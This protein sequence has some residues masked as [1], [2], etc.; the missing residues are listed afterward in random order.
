MSASSNKGYLGFEKQTAMGT[1][2]TAGFKFIGCTMVDAQPENIAATAAPV[3]GG[4]AFPEDGYKAAHRAG[5]TFAFEA[6][7]DD[8]GWL[9]YYMG[10][11]CGYS[12]D[13]PVAD[14]STHTFYMA[15]GDDFTIPWVTFVRSAGDLI[16][17]QLID[18]KIATL[19]LAFAAG[20]PVVAT[21]GVIAREAA[22]FSLS[23]TVTLDN[24]PLLVTPDSNALAQI[25]YDEDD[26]L[27][28]VVTTGVIVDFANVLTN[29]E[30]VIGSYRLNDVTLL[31]RAIG[32]TWTGII[33]DDYMWRA[34]YYGAVDGTTWSTDP[35][36]AKCLVKAVSGQFITGT[37]QY[38]LQFE[39]GEA[40]WT[41][42]R[43]PLASQSLIGFTATAAVTVPASGEEFTFTLVNDTDAAYSS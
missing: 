4:K 40:M 5:G 25:D 30:F 26:T 13:T 35:V 43:C 33:E 6:R 7:A 42:M 38:S 10:G 19:R 18:A 27:E 29:N 31:S 12:A 3:I 39:C 36:L 34:M 41:V 9:L 14:A 22:N 23:P 15:A 17:D 21:F 16:K 32:I 11:A 37:T 2:A 8:I 24:K 28:D 20:A 1:A